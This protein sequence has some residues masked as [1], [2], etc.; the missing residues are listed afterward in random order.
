MDINLTTVVEI[1]DMRHKVFEVDIY[2]LKHWRNITKY[3]SIYH[4]IKIA[5][6]MSYL[7]HVVKHIEDQ[8]INFV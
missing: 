7:K 2:F 1:I 5:P 6:L 4:I 3:V 8:V